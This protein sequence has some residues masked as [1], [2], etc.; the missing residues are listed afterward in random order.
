[1]RLG[2]RRLTAG[3]HVSL[4]RFAKVPFAGREAVLAYFSLYT[5]RVAL[6]SS[7]LI[8]FDTSSV[9]F[10]YEHYRGN[11]VD[12][13]T[14]R[15]FSDVRDRHLRKGWRIGRDRAERPSENR[16]VTLLLR[17]GNR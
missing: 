1:M 15:V 2:I 12:R 5:R 17:V 14:Q 9:T 8:G 10:G 6:S 11:F 3:Q 4:G 13:S 16:S 7:R